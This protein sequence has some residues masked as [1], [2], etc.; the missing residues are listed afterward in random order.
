MGGMAQALGGESGEENIVLENDDLGCVGGQSRAET[1]QMRLE[2]SPLA[3][4]GMFIDNDEFNAFGQSDA[5]ELGA[6]ALTS[7][8]PLGEGNAVDAV[9]SVPRVGNKALG[10]WV[11]L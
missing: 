11:S 7:V 10:R 8:G 5:L 4:G 6:G 2:N 9:E 3:V 1:R